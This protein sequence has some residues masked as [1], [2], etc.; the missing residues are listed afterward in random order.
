[1]KINFFVRFSTRYGQELSVIG[2]IDALGNNQITKALPLKW[3]NAFLWYGEI[4]VNTK[5]L[6]EPIQYKYI[7]KNENGLLIQEWGEDRIIPIHQLP[8]HSIQLIDTWNHAGTTENV[9]FTN[10]FQEYLLPP[11]NIQVD[12]QKINKQITHFFK[13]KAP[14]LAVNQMVCIMG[15]G[16]TLGN[17]DTQQPALLQ[18]E[19]NWYTLALSI[20][21]HELP[22]S[23]KYGIFDIENHR[24]VAYEQGENRVLQI[25]QHEELT[26]VH[27]GFVQLDTS[28]FKGAGVAIPVF[29]LRTNENFGVGEFT[30]IKSLADWCSTTGMQLIQLLPVNDTSATHTWKDSYPYAAISAFAL[31]PLYLDVTELAGKKYQKI[32][33]AYSGKREQLN[34]AVSVDYEEVLQIK[35]DII[36]QLFSQLSKETFNSKDYK[37]FFKENQHWLEPYAAFC[38]LRDENGTPDFNQWNEFS[39]YDQKKIEKLLQPKTKH[40]NKIAIHYF[41]QYHLHRQL[42]N[43]VNYTHEKGIV[44]KGDI[45]IGIYRFG[46]DAWV[47]PALYHMDMQAGAPPDDFATKGQNWG[48]PTYNWE[49]MEADGFD[50][51]KKRFH[52][53]SYYFDAFRI[54]H[55]LGF[56]RIWSIPLHAVEG[57]LG[58]FVQTLPLEQN[59]IEAQLGWFNKER[60]CSPFINDTVLW[61]MFGPNH[62]KFKE[63]LEESHNHQY[64]LKDEFSTQRKVQH[65]FNRLEQT[66]QNLHLKQGLFDLIS[67][68]IFIEENGK[69]HFRFGMRDT[70]SFQHLSYDVQVK[71]EHLYNYYFFQRQDEFWKRAAMSKLPALKAATNML[72]CGEDLGMVPNCVP[73]VMQQLGILSLE[74]QRMPKQIGI[75]FFHPKDAPYLSVVTPSTHDM[76]TIRGWWEEDRDKTQRFYELILNQKGTAPFFCEDWINE[77]IIDQHLYSPAMWAIFQMQDLLGMDASIRRNNPQEERIN[78]PANPTHYWNYRMHISLEELLEKNSFNQRLSEKINQSG[79][80][81]V[82]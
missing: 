43:A 5:E 29:S 48:F 46:V 70:T 26:I 52:Q 33:E 36:H 8:H 11:V 79:R 20:P 39:E 57:I 74:I 72:I 73:D 35:W 59:E 81:S 47:N 4:E 50:W 34:Q 31:H 25:E 9:F 27:D 18:K 80:S 22:I 38:Y 32:I 30:S 77:K 23:Y 62:N 49:V 65:Y 75:E 68:I 10:P 12:T 17:W 1:M 76:S 56:F 14:L 58:Y 54:D 67:N 61:E 63:F 45:P 51:W 19:G 78:V 7:L 53:M 15:A 82:K 66:E 3:Y 16:D 37:S 28:F 69:Y 60:F 2:N 44:I 24:F 6:K 55:I 71:L 41:V 42:S 21:P 40:Y 64:H 13:V